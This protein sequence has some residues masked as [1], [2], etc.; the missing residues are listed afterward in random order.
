MKAGTKA[1]QR[2][3]QGLLDAQRERLGLVRSEEFRGLVPGD[4]VR[5]KRAGTGDRLL[6]FKAH[7][8][9]VKKGIEWVDVLDVDVYK[10]PDGTPR[11]TTM[12][13]PVRPDQVVV[14]RKT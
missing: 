3:V 10:G 5:L 11:R 9:N 7:F 14:A 4:K 12:V 8:T 6:E 1:N 13:I 2:L